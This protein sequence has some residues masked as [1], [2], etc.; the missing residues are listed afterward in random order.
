MRTEFVGDRP[1]DTIIGELRHDLPARA[2]VCI[3]TTE[4]RRVVLFATKEPHCLGDLLL[5]YAEGD[6]PVHVEAVISNYPTLGR[7][8]ER[9]EDSLPSRESRGPRSSRARGG[10]SRRAGRL[11]PGVPRA[12]EVHAVSAPRLRGGPIPPASSTSTTRFSPPSSVHDPYQQAFDRGVKIIGATAHYRHGRSGRRPDH[13]AGRAPRTHRAHGGRPWRG[14]DATWRRSSRARAAT[15]LPEEA[16]LSRAGPRGGCLR[17]NRSRSVRRARALLIMLS[18]A[19]AGLGRINVARMRAGESWVSRTTSEACSAR[20]DTCCSSAISPVARR[21]RRSA[22]TRCSRYGRRDGELVSDDGHGESEPHAHALDEIERC[23]ARRDRREAA[24]EPARRRSAARSRSASSPPSAGCPSCITSGSIARREWPNQEISDGADLAAPRH[25]ASDGRRSS[26]RTS[27]AAATTCTRFAAIRDVQNICRRLVRQRRRS[28]HAR[29]GR[30]RLRR[31]TS[32][33]GR[34]ISRWKPGSPSSA[35][36][37]SSGCPR[38][39]S[40]RGVRW[41]NAA[42]LFLPEPFRACADASSMRG[43]HR[44][45]SYSTA[46]APEPR[47]PG[48]RARARRVVGRMGRISPGARAARPGRRR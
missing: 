8:V 23:V 17:A 9:F 18:R 22:T 39:R 6:I 41:A 37:R 48:A 11:R 40:A 28:R 19:R 2:N 13:R 29:R 34:A 14:P 31:A 7:L 32:A 16:R 10:D 4:P 33:L 21:R 46:S 3:A 12:G 43:V 45:L 36:S 30:R 42:P 27:V 44:P 25:A 38:Q 26:S 35:R 15:L 5:R 24:R 1:T 20:M 47:R